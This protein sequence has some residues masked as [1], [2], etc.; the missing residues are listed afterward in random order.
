MLDIG[1]GTPGRVKISISPPCRFRP[2]RPFAPGR[3][4]HPTGVLA[5]GTIER[6]AATGEGLP[7]VPAEAGG[8]GLQGV[9]LQ[10]RRDQ[11]GNLAVTG[12]ENLR[13]VESTETRC[14]TCLSPS[15]PVR[16]DSP[17]AVNRSNVHGAERFEFVVGYRFLRVHTRDEAV[18]ATLLRPPGIRFSSRVRSGAMIVNSAVSSNGVW[19]GPPRS[20]AR[21]TRCSTAILLDDGGAEELTVHG[22]EAFELVVVQLVA[23]VEPDVGELLR[24]LHVLEHREN[25]EDVVLVDVRDHQDVDGPGAA[26]VANPSP[27]GRTASALPH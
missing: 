17:A 10:Q 21:G 24:P 5:N 27:G 11:T 22:S 1:P 12:E 13:A 6:I 2:A 16:I 23:S 18:V 26:S 8:P 4:F 3:L 15:G 9:G 14:W 19:G 20:H 7:M 25:T